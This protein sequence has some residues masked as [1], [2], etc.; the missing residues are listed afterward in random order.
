MNIDKQGNLYYGDMVIGDREATESEVSAWTLARTPVAKAVKAAEIRALEAPLADEAAR[1]TRQV[2]LQT[3][4]DWACKQ[5]PNLTTE[6]VHAALM[7][8]GT[9]YF[10]LYNLEQAVKAIRDRP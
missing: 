10:K 9:G 8:Q 2:T 5:A 4:L 7:A 3:A 6:Q 1:M